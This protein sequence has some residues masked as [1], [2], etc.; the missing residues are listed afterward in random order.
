[1]WFFCLGHNFTVTMCCEGILSIEALPV[2]YTHNYTIYYTFT[3]IAFP[4]LNFVVDQTWQFS[5][6]P[7]IRKCCQFLCSNASNDSL[8]LGSTVVLCAVHHNIT[9]WTAVLIHSFS[10][11]AYNAFQTDKC[12]MASLSVLPNS[13][14]NYL[15]TLTN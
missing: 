4:S 3:T 14:N 11:Y 7:A 12:E 13:K 9:C 2:V 6:I 1:M 10:P 8:P 5:H 15:Y